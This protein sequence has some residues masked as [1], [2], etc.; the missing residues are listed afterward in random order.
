MCLK[1]L[2]CSSY[3]V[4]TAIDNQGFTKE[5]NWHT[6][7]YKRGMTLPELVTKELDEMTREELVNFAFYVTG[8]QNDAPDLTE[9]LKTAWGC[10]TTETV[11]QYIIATTLRN[12][13]AEWKKIR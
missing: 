12:A 6:T 3:D 13:L 4:V 7:C 11:K 2:H 1:C 10:F 8:W 5:V 9:H